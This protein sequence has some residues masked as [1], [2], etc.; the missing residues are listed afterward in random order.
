VAAW[1]RTLDFNTLGDILTNA[2]VP[3]GLIYR[4]PDNVEDAQYA[5]REMVQRVF[6]GILG[7]K[8]PMPAVVPRLT[9]TPGQT[10]WCGGDVGAHTEEVL[11]ELGLSEMER[12]ALRM[13]GVTAST[14]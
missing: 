1:T 4:A 6:D 12:A 8:V 5:A 2:H 9:R 11:A 13:A 7:H 10:R 14:E 3:H